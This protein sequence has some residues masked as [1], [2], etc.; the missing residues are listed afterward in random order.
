MAHDNPIDAIQSAQRAA[1]AHA[2]EAKPGDHWK[3]DGDTMRL[4]RADGSLV[5]AMSFDAWVQFEA[6]MEDP[7]RFL[8]PEFVWCAWV[9]RRGRWVCQS[10]LN[11]SGRESEETCEA[12]CSLLD[13]PAYRGMTLMSAAVLELTRLRGESVPPTKASRLRYDELADRCSKLD[14]DLRRK[15]AECDELRDR[16]RDLEAQRGE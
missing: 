3:R 15:R 2:L 14:M 7:S 5:C 1:F 4:C 9:G 16:V 6:M 10:E 8:G 13:S 12:L 11:I